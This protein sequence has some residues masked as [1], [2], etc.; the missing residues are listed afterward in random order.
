MFVILGCVDI[1]CKKE[2]DIKKLVKAKGEKLSQ[3]TNEGLLH[4]YRTLLPF[5]PDP[6]LSL[7]SSVLSLRIQNLSFSRREAKIIEISPL[8]VQ[9]LM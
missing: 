9:K 6:M 4:R 1:D 8:F 2:E 7:F 3:C 5:K